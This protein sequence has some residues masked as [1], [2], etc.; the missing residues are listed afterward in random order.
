MNALELLLNRRS[1]SRLTTPA[2]QGEALQNILAAGMRAPDHGALRP[3]RFIVMQDEGIDRFSQLLHQAAVDG[4]LGVEAE[5]KAKSAPYRAP[6]IIAVLAKVME[7]SKIPEWEQ[8][9]SA[10]CTVHAMQMAAVAQGFGG[11][12]RTGSWTDDDTVRTGLG[13]NEYDKVVGFLYL[14]T[15]VLKAPGKVTTPDMTNFVSYF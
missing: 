9:V 3:W 15:P 2:P 8:V 10:G 12:W 5:E 1:A 14:G 11:I 7:N 6:L 4:H 13:C